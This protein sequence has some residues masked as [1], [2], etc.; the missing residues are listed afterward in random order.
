MKSIRFLLLASIVGFSVGCATTAHKK[1]GNTSTSLQEAA[2]GVDRSNAQLDVVLTALSDLVNSPHANL[3]SQFNAFSNAVTKL[4]ADAKSV[5]DQAAAM[6]EQGA[7]YFQQ[8]DTELA[9]IQNENIRTRSLDRKNTVSARFDK[10]RASYTQAR[11]DFAPFLSDL[12]DIRTA[13]TADLTSGGLAS[14]K[15]ASDKAGRNVY[16]L[17]ASLTGLASDF[18]TLGVSLSASTP[19]S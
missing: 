12:R 6:Q 8:W 3:T 2:H 13:L 1:A 5:N 17:R 15:G 14:V 9:T 11:A 10:V 7:A 16:P 18:K 19:A 4:E